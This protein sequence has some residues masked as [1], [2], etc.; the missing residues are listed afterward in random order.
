MDE[1]AYEL[2]SIKIIVELMLTKQFSRE[3]IAAFDA[4]QEHI[5]RQIANLEILEAN[6]A[7]LE[8]YRRRQWTSMQGILEDVRAKLLNRDRN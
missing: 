2:S 6:P 1:L 5:G 8:D 7:A 4:F 3:P